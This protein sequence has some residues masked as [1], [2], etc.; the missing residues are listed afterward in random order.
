MAIGTHLTYVPGLWGFVFYADSAHAKMWQWSLHTM[1]LT[2]ASPHLIGSVRSARAPP[3]GYSE[4][5]VQMLVSA[6]SRTILAPEA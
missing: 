5:Q 3:L 2:G 4:R 6:F 1:S